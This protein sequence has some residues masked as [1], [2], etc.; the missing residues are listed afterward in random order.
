M[1]DVTLRPIEADDEPFLRTML[2]Q[3]FHWDDTDRVPVAE[4]LAT[5]A[6]IYV[7]GWGRHGDTGLIAELA[8]VPVGAAW[9]RLYEADI[10]TFGHVAPDIP[11]ISTVAVAPGGRGLG[12][13]SRLVDELLQ[14]LKV[15]GWRA[16]SLSCE[17]GNDRARMLYERRGFAPVGRVDDADTMLVWLS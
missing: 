5:H 10:H 6:P 13:G 2:V 15:Q 11:E 4:I 17:D 12:L 8:G 16:A 9:A 7:D 3:A 1:H 14:A